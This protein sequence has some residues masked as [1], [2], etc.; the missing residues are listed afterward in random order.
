MA[1]PAPAATA[2]VTRRAV[3]S[4]SFA[5]K[6]EVQEAPPPRLSRRRE[7]EERGGAL[8]APARS[9]TVAYR[10]TI[11]TTDMRGAG[12]DAAVFVELLGNEGTTGEY[13]LHGG[14]RGG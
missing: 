8:L 4:V 9:L 3:G 5:E 14:G 6:P 7:L 11:A 13:W 2:P 1:K 10:L 12:T